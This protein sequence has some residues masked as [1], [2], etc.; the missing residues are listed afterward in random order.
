MDKQNQP[1]SIQQLSHK[2][3]IPKSTIRFWEKEFKDL[4]VPYRTKGGQRRYTSEH[5]NLLE[6]IKK[7]KEKGMNLSEIKR[8]FENKSTQG[9]SQFDR[10][11]ILAERLT[12]LI[13][14]EV[15]NFL[16]KSNG[17]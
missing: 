7:L 17:N 10:I 9:Y 16:D 13:K 2:L 12:Q 11:D 6:G 1:F 4:I 14:N 15:I 5:I 8:N 3:N